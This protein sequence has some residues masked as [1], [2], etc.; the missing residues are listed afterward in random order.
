MKRL[1]VLCA[2]IAFA[3]T[4]F[5]QVSNTGFPN[6]GTFE[7]GRFDAINLQNLNT[8]LTMPISSTKGRGTDLNFVISNNSLVWRKAGATWTPYT[9][10]NG[11]PTW[12]WSTTTL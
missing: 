12:G 3:S 5:A 2:L 11:I 8:N 4:A 9:D 7:R 10:V 6:F 1:L